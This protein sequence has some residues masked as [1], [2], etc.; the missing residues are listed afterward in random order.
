MQR[1]VSS[2]PPLSSVLIPHP[3]IP[4]PL[5]CLSS[6]HIFASGRRNRRTR[7]LPEHPAASRRDRRTSNLGGDSDSDVLR[8]L[9]VG[10]L[11]LRGLCHQSLYSRRRSCCHRLIRLWHKRS[12]S[13]ELCAL[14]ILPCLKAEDYFSC[15][16]EIGTREGRQGSG[17]GFSLTITGSGEVTGKVESPY[18]TSIRAS[19]LQ[20]SQPSVSFDQALG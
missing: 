11:R 10:V 7:N 4:G 16:W 6:S 20:L 5:R 1:Q 9:G 2:P 19:P 12:R 8:I 15:K 13:L 17:C 18:T 3:L 14:Q